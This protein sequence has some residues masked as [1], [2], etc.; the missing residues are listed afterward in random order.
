M[1]EFFNFLA[2][3]DVKSV[4]NMNG[5]IDQISLTIRDKILSN[6][7]QYLVQEFSFFEELSQK[8]SEEIILALVPLTFEEGVTILRRRGAAKGIY[9]I[10]SG[11]VGVFYLDDTNFIDTVDGDEYFGDI[12]F[13]EKKSHFDYKCLSTVVCLYIEKEILEEIMFNYKVDLSIAKDTAKLRL[14]YLKHLKKQYL[15]SK[16]QFEKSFENEKSLEKVGFNLFPIYQDTEN[17]ELLG[18][19]DDLREFDSKPVLKM[20]SSS[21]IYGIGGEVI[22]TDFD[23]DKNSS[24]L[25]PPK[26]FYP[27]LLATPSSDPPIKLFGPST[28]LVNKSLLSMPSQPLKQTTELGIIAQPSSKLDLETLSASKKDNLRSMFKKKE[29]GENKSN[30]LK[31]VSN[32]HIGE[33]TKDSD[34]SLEHEVLKIESR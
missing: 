3:K 21:A 34:D 24:P 26:Q 19:N 4:V 25:E 1:K 32:M 6:S 30:F 16:L 7:S 8:L 13:L 11:S 33:D 9:L 2:K 5:Y 27:T 18:N 15:N 28:H 10:L 14:K 29:E 12:L 31:V 22:P 20:T 17:D 23:T